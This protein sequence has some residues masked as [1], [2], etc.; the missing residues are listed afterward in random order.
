MP[1]KPA[2]RK[3]A[4]KPPRNPGRPRKPPKGED[5]GGRCANAPPGWLGWVILRSMGRALGDVA[6][7]GGAEKVCEPRLPKLPPRPAVASALVTANAS[8][9]TSA[10][11]TSSRRARKRGMTSSQD[12]RSTPQYWYPTAALS[13]V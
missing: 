2:P 5:A 10:Q 1:S 4:N 3:P 13:E 6:V 11:S 8:T 7:E 12:T 9:A